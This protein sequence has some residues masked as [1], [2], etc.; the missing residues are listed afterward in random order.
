MKIYY[1]LVVALSA[2]ALIIS[3]E[4]QTGDEQNEAKQIEAKDSLHGVSPVLHGSVWNNPVF[5]NVDIS[6]E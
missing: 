6:N 1:F 4:R 2:T 5:V 3:C